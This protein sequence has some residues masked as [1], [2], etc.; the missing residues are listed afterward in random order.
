MSPCRRRE[1]CSFFNREMKNMP[2]TAELIKKDF[3]ENNYSNCAR[4][5]LFTYAEK[6]DRSVDRKTEDIIAKFSDTL[7]PHE[8]N[9]VKKALPDSK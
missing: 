6:K 4:N 1:N 7:Y 2:V 8:L 9:K 3:C 5:Y